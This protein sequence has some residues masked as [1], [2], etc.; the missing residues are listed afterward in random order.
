VGGFANLAG[1]GIEAD[2]EGQSILLGN[3][4]LMQG[5]NV[6]L[7]GL[8][9]EAAR[10][11]EAANTVV[12]LAVDGKGVGLIAIADTVKESSREAIEGLHKLGLKVAMITGDNRQTAEAVARQVGIDTVFAEVAPGDKAAHV[13]SLQAEGEVVGMV[14]DGINDA[15]ALAQADVGMAIGTGT[16][17]AMEAADV[18]LMRGDLRSVAQALQLSRA[19]IRVIQ[20]NLGWAF[21]YNAILIPIAA[22]ILYPFAWAPEFLRQ[23]H[24]IL[25]ALAMAFSSVSVVSNS[26]RL[27]RAKIQ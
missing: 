8:E 24:P 12:W 27:R 15:P 26:L 13:K 22:G 1:M 5:H 17:V 14:G 4:K 7:N 18:T 23:L 11:Q 25:A 21:G 2:V 10:L 19:T 20:Q 6:T 3:T 16:D 9:A